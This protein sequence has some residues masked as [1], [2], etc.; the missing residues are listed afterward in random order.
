MKYWILLLVLAV[1]LF[2]RAAKAEMEVIIEAA[3]PSFQA[4]CTAE[5]SQKYEASAKS[6]KWS[7]TEKELLKDVWAEFSYRQGEDQITSVRAKKLRQVAYK[8]A[9]NLLFHIR[10][11]G[12]NAT[13]AFNLA[14][15]EAFVTQLYTFTEPEKNGIRARMV[16]L[17]CDFTLQE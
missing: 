1:G 6:N 3:P 4:V 12:N 2:P 7:G 16:Q 15:K 13:Y 11:G 17:N 9:N 10:D 14:L 8:D 5:K